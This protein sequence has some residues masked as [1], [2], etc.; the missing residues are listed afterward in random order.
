MLPQPVDVREKHSKMDWH[1]IKQNLSPRGWR[2]FFTFLMIFVGVNIHVTIGSHRKLQSNLL[3]NC[4]SNH[5]LFETSYKYKN[6]L[7]ALSK[8]EDLQW[9]LSGTKLILQCL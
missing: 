7:R 5:P 9:M 2:P 8:G 6:I 3:S 1:F 4:P